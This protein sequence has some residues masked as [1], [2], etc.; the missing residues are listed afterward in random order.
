MKNLNTLVTIN[1]II[2]HAGVFHADDVL[3]CAMARVINPDVT[4]ERNNNPKPEDVES[5]GSNGIWVADVGLGRFD[6]HQADV[7]T[8]EDGSKYAACG[9]LYEVWKDTLTDGADLDNI[10]LFEKMMR[11]IER[12]DNGGEMATTN[13]ITNSFRP[14]W[15][16]TF[17]MDDGFNKAVMFMWNVVLGI[18]YPLYPVEIGSDGLPLPI[19]GAV[20]QAGGEYDGDE[21]GII[22]LEG[23][24]SSFRN[25]DTVGV[26]GQQYAVYEIF[27]QL[28]RAEQAQLRAD[29]YLQKNLG[30]HV[31]DTVVFLG[32][33]LPWM[34]T[35]IPAK[36]LYV[37]YPAIRGGWNIQCV[38]VAV[39]DRTTK[40]PFPVEWLSNP[41][42]RPAGCTFVH[43]AGFLAGFETREDAKA[44]AKLLTELVQK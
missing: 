20:H 13:T 17:S 27:S 14:C 9:L 34:R 29:K 7:K 10:V 3:C 37:S 4:I 24:A 2:V 22:M 15:D 16:D 30:S 5:D 1:K 36:A 41:E 39:G 18:L 19:H 11:Y 42:S 31:N 21:S 35:L 8:Y 12:A 44:A 33:C 23:Y 32:K 25:D 28:A 38:P 26:D 6:H 40:K 43:P